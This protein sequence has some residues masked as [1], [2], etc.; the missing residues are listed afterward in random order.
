MPEQ[1]V[2]ALMALMTVCV[3]TNKKNEIEMD[4]QTSKELMALLTVC[5]LDALVLAYIILRSRWTGWRL[6]ATV[7]FVFFGVMTFMSQ[8]ESL[9]FHILPSG[10]LPR[11]ILVGV[12][13]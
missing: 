11:L 6:I 7:F 9:V 8:I 2:A 10:M 4:T 3:V 12:L 1:A 5:F 13:I